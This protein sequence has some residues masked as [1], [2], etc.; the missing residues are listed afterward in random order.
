V[1]AH[2]CAQSSQKN[3]EAAEALLSQGDYHQASEKLWGAAAV[4][5]KAIAERRGWPYGA[6]RDLNRAISSLAQET[7]RRG[8][9]VMFGSAG[10]L[11]TNFY[12]DWLTPDQVIELASSVRELLEELS[13]LA[14]A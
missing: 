8:L 2:E 4:M 10:H 3:L 6:H 5:V 12:E 11:H 13:Q 14:E 9:I 7:G 1:I